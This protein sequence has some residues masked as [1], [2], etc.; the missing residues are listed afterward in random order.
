MEFIIGVIIIIAWVVGWKES[1]R[2]D[3]KR[4]AKYKRDLEQE[5]YDNERL[6]L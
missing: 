6:G 3:K 5:A 1:E 4:A 2:K